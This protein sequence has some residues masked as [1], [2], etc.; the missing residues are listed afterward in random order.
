MEI[1]KKNSTKEL[2][3]LISVRP[4]DATALQNTDIVGMCEADVC[5]QLNIARH[6][7][8]TFQ[9]TNSF[10][11]HMLDK[12]KRDRANFVRRRVELAKLGAKLV[13][14]CIDEVKLDAKNDHILYKL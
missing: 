4:P 6:Q 7:L 9:S 5:G 8:N 1:V 13:F 11:I 2:N 10:D 12:F 14:N 3:L